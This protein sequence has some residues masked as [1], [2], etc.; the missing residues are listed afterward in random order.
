M[1]QILAA[2]LSVRE[3]LARTSTEPRWPVYGTRSFAGAQDDGVTGT[4]STFSRTAQSGQGQLSGICD[5]R[6]PGA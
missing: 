1:R 2:P 5:Q 3:R 4:K 6:V